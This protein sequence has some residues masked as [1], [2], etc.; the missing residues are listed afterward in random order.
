MDSVIS[1]AG[2]SGSSGPHGDSDSQCDVEIDAADNA[3]HLEFSPEN[4]EDSLFLRNLAL[5]YLKLLAKLL[6]PASTIQTIIEDMQSIHDLSQSQL[7]SKLNEKLL[8]MGISDDSI[9]ALIDDLR[10]EDFF[11]TH[12]TNTLKTDL[13]RKTVFKSQF[14][15]VEPVPLCLGQNEAGKDS[16]AHYVPIDQT[17]NVL[18]Q[19]QS[20]FEQYKQVHA[21]TE[22]DNVL[23]DVWDGENVTENTLKKDGSLGLILYQDAFEVVNPLGSGEKSTKYLLCIFLWQT[24]YHTI[25]QTLIKCN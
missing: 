17:L 9:R 22:T 1:L 3:D 19:S 6:L 7:F 15:Y 20:V 8:Q 4:I 25:G 12:N 5:F 21:H 2:V 16:F 14:N 18:F 23:Q 24:F 13:R 10:A 11:R